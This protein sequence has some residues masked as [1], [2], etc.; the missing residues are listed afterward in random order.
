MCDMTVVPFRVACP[1]LRA[2]A[3]MQLLA[4]TALH[5]FCFPQ[6]LCAGVQMQVKQLQRKD[7]G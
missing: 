3:S 2:C 5:W 7:L 4:E 6:P 1:L